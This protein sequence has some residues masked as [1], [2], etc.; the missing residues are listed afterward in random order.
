MIPWLALRCVGQNRACP[1][2]IMDS[3]LWTCFILHSRGPSGLPRGAIKP[4]PSLS[5]Y[6][7]RFLQP[8]VWHQARESRLGCDCRDDGSA[9]SAKQGAETYV[10]KAMKATR[11]PP[12]T[13]LGFPWSFR[14]KPFKPRTQARIPGETRLFH[15]VHRTKVL[16]A[17]Q[18][19]PP[20][21]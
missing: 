2:Q 3:A 11:Y 21:R 7:A 14:R 4:L 1:A 12:R 6:L 15:R 20:G 19:I 17:K 10:K 16:R 9:D 13:M 5:A 18:S 8:S